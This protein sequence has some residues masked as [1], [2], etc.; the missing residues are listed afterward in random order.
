MHFQNILEPMLTDERVC[1]P[2]IKWAETVINEVAIA[3]RGKYNDLC[4]TVS[5]ALINMPDHGL[6]SLEEEF[7]RE[8]AGNLSTAVRESAGRASG[9]STRGHDQ[10]GPATASTIQVTRVTGPGPPRLGVSAA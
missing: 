5:A 3:P 4:D 6:L 7:R 9:N 8:G 1:A 10:C 2:D